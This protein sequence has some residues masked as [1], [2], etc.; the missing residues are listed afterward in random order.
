M[1]A[2]LCFVASVVNHRTLL[3]DDPEAPSL[4]S[5]ENRRASA[6]GCGRSA[7]SHPGRIAVGCVARQR[8]LGFPRAVRRPRCRSFRHAADARRDDGDRAARR[9]DDAVAAPAARAAA[10]GA[11]RARA[12]GAR[13]AVFG[14]SRRLL[15]LRLGKAARAHPVDRG[16]RH[17]RCRISRWA[18]TIGPSSSITPR[19]ARG[20]S[21]TAA[22]R[23]RSRAGMSS[24]HACRRSRRRIRRRFA[25]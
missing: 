10:R 1:S 14:R 3:A 20:S 23:A 19:A 12:R 18:S 24:S 15:R 16:R 6:L 21:A 8:G 2:D 5:T 9:H 7:V 22:T 11:R 25:C 13:P 17:C 4:A